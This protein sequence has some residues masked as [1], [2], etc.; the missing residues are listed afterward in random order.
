[1]MVK[2]NVVEAARTTCDKCTEKAD[3]ITEA[4]DALCVEHKDEVKSGSILK[5]ASLE[6]HIDAR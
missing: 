5:H 3:V 4:G 6:K 2:K 1:M